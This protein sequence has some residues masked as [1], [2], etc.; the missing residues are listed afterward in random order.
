MNNIYS[1]DIFSMGSPQYQLLQNSVSNSSRVNIFNN[2]FVSELPMTKEEITMD[3]DSDATL[4]PVASSIETG[5][6]KVNNSINIKRS[7]KN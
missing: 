1:E 2:K 4:K 6:I 3:A 5:H 7:L